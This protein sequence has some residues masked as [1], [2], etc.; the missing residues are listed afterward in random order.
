MAKGLWGRKKKSGSDEKKIQEVF[1]VV[2]KNRERVSV[3]SVT[4]VPTI[5]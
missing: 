4:K 2:S 5:T 1:E 3:G